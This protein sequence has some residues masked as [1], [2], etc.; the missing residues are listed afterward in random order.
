[1]GG[2]QERTY[3]RRLLGAAFYSSNV[4]HL[5]KLC[6]RNATVDDPGCVYTHPLCCSGAF[7]LRKVWGYYIHIGV[8]FEVAC[9][10]ELGK[11]DGLK[12]EMSNKCESHAFC[13]VQ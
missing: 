3:K 10:S 11:F 5:K 12:S 8:G 6:R 9:L 2:K 1:M 4:E 7:M 13:V